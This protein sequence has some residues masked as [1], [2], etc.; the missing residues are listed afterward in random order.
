MMPTAASTFV[1]VHGAWIGSRC[2]REVADILRA[3]GHRVFTPTLTGLGE[4][5][6][7]LSRSVDL[8]TH[9]TDIVN[10]ITFERLSD[11]VLVGHSYSGMVITGVAARVPDGT[12][13]SI[14]FLDAFVPGDDQSL[15]DIVGEDAARLVYGDKD[16]VPPPVWIAGED[17]TLARC[18][19]HD[20]T[21][22]P[23]ASKFER[24]GSTA[25]RE[26]IPIKTFVLATRPS[27]AFFAAQAERLRG[28]PRWRVE[29]IACGHM[30]ML[31][32]P[33]ETAT[34]LLRAGSQP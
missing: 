12:I 30:T 22:H 28:D 11:V 34:L 27:S 4:R 15:A 5:S 10:V 7:L 9:V 1:L 29:E 6:H 25:A 16:P 18:F 13:R 2:W 14:V 24:V 8:T 33:E 3:K 23:R 21:P 26:R 20:S 31:D 17:A 32:L 19:S